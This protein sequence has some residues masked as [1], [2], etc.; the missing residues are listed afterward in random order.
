MKIIFYASLLYFS[1]S[2]FTYSTNISSITSS[3][4]FFSRSF[5]Y[6]RQD[7][8]SLR[9]L[10]FWNWQW[11]IWK[12]FNGSSSP[13]PPRQI[14]A[15]LTNSAP[16]TRN[17]PPKLASFP[18]WTFRW[19]DVWWPTWPH[20]WVRLKPIPTTAKRRLSS[21][22]NRRHRRRNCKCI[23]C[24]RLTQLRGFKFSNRMEFF[25]PMPMAP[26]CNWSRPDCRMATSPWYFRRE[27][28]PRARH[29]R[30]R[31]RPRARP[32]QLWSRSLREPPA[33]RPR[34]H[35]PRPQARRP[36]QRGA[37][38]RSRDPLRPTASNLPPTARPTVTGMSRRPR[39]MVTPAIRSSI[40][41]STVL[42]S[43]NLSRS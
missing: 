41:A 21:Q 35:R 18:V 26:A 4:R 20:A 19:R 40:H 23:S 13:W 30:R 36:R 15:S 29:R 25:S 38:W 1:I 9:R 7:I 22:S 42:P 14:R 10:T 3:N 8:R 24:L 27:R 33:Q 17:A 28:K 31:P 32:Y 6:S 5:C 43:R 2:N 11:S 39:R 37:R 34:H 12:T 16:V